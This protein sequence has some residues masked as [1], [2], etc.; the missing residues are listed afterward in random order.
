MVQ[1]RFTGPTDALSYAR[2]Q[3]PLQGEPAPQWYNCALLGQ[4][5]RSRMPEVLSPLG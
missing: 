5:M 2:M 1:L 3:T 4:P